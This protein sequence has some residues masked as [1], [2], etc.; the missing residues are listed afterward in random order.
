MVAA[1]TP[2][3]PSGLEAPPRCRALPNGPRTPTACAPWPWPCSSGPKL[4][5]GV[6]T[7]PRCPA[8]AP[9]QRL[10]PGP[11]P[12]AELRCREEDPREAPG[13]WAQHS[14]PPTCEDAASPQVGGDGPQQVPHVGAGEAGQP[15]QVWFGEAQ[16][17]LHGPQPGWN[18][19]DASW[20][21]PGSRGQTPLL[22]G[23]RVLTVR[24]PEGGAWGRPSTAAAQP[25]APS[26]GH[27]PV[28]ARKPGLREGVPEGKLPDPHTNPP[29]R[30][31]RTAVG[32]RMAGTAGRAGRGDGPQGGE[33]FGVT[34]PE[35]LVT[36]RRGTEGAVGSGQRRLAGRGRAAAPPCAPGGRRA[37][38]GPGAQEATDGCFSQ[39]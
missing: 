16:G 20:A 9:Q 6:R 12:G 19:T 1:W 17:L 3:A 22:S 26:H 31:A 37:G 38:P 4:T 5:P 11:P 10:G 14:C 34:C 28:T 36:R 15:L 13:P 18:H 21:G 23:P 2:A 8:A 27:H 25:G 24:G 35:G 32:W 30:Q 39:R 29:G 33:G 7:R